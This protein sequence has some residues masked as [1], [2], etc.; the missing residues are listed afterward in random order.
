MFTRENL[1]QSNKRANG[2][3]A[4]DSLEHL[5]MK[6]LHVKLLFFRR[7]LV[8]VVKGL[9]CTLHDCQK[10]ENVMVYKLVPKLEGVEMCLRSKINSS[11]TTMYFTVY[12]HV[13]RS[14]RFY[15]YQQ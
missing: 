5:G 8:Y 15:S 1:D 11:Y 12:M 6:M 14:S 9:R 4:Q 2:K 13:K 10:I 3:N 7:S